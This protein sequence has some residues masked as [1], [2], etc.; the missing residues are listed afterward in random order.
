MES[1]S[2]G[3]YELERERDYSEWCVCLCLYMNSIGN[4]NGKIVYRCGKRFAASILG[5]D[6]MFNVRVFSVI[7]DVGVVLHI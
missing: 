6:L 5:I 3:M 7:D 1:F 4:L 2:T